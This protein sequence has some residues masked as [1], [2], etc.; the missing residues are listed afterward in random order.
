MWVC[1]CVC[2]YVCVCICFGDFESSVS[3]HGRVS[4]SR[5]YQA[6]YLPK[7]KTVQ[8]VITWPETLSCPEKPMEFSHGRLP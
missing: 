5:N 8:A 2:V 3:S 6:D 1:V 7:Q 4:T